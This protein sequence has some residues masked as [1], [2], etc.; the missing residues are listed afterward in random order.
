MQSLRRATRGGGLRTVCPRCAGLLYVRYD[1]TL[2]RKTINRD[3][4]PTRLPTMWRY[5]D[6]LPEARPGHAQGKGSLR[7]CA[8][9]KTLICS[10]K[11][12]A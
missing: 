12:T 7:C 6:V 11:M 5:A 1:L 8:A 3:V 9:A 10:L 4:L 2:L